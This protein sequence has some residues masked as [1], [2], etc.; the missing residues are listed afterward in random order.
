MKEITNKIKVCH[1]TTVHTPFDIRIFQKECKT[2]AREGYDVILIAQNKKNEIVDQVKIVALP[3]EKNRIHRMFILTLKTF[4]YALRQKADLYHFH[5]PELLPIGVLLKLFTGKKII[6]DV[7]EDY[8]KQMLCKP[9]I[10]R[11][12]RK[13]VALLIKGIDRFSSTNFLTV[14]SLQVRT[15]Q[16]LSPITIHYLT[17]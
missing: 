3:K 12:A 15:L 13:S 6:Y 9:Y 8:V 1:I 10:P 4:W 16:K 5:D 17:R 11:I 7:H 14:L 2:L